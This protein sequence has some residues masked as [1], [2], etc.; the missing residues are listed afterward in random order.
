MIE[1]HAHNMVT[2]P[3]EKCMWI[4]VLMSQVSRHNSQSK[5]KKKTFTFFP[6]FYSFWLAVYSVQTYSQFN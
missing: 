2:E 1:E 3:P 6:L 5:K 4:E